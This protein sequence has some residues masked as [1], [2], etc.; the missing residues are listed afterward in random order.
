M[1]NKIKIYLLL[2]ISILF[3]NV[4]IVKADMGAPEIHGYEVTIT[5]TEGATLYDYNDKE[6]Q[7]IPYDTKLEVLYEYESNGEMYASVNYNSKSGV[8]KLS[9]TKP[10]TTEFN[11]E[12][13]DK[14]SSVMKLYVF[15]SGCYLFKGPSKNYDK[16]MEEEIPVGTVLEYEYHDDVWSYVEYDGKSGWIMNYSYSDL[17]SDLYTAVANI[18]SQDSKVMTVSE[19]SELHEEPSADSKVVSTSIPAWEELE[20]KYVYKKAKSQYVYV[21]YEDDAGWMYV[22][23]SEYN[24][25]T[26]N[27]STSV[28]CGYIYIFTD[29]DM[30]SKPNDLNSKVSQKLPSSSEYTYDYCFTKSGKEW[31][32]I[33]YKNK[34]YWIYLDLNSYEEDESFTSSTMVTTY[35]TKDTITLYESPSKDAK[36]VS[37]TI[38]KDVTVESKFSQYIDRTSW[39]YIEYDGIKGWADESSLT[40]QSYSLLCDA[41]ANKEEEEEKS[42][43]TE[44]K[45]D[46]EEESNTNSS[47]PLGLIIAISIGAAI[48]CVLV[49]VVIIVLINKKKK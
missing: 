41:S 9:D 45:E 7:K 34:N 2:I 1:K 47:F 38:S 22:A 24:E 21:E 12:D 33:T 39:A 44:D 31:Y 32:R 13:F 42:S 10:T 27:A 17:Y 6:I 20:Y 30:Y 40:F 5:N 29:K 18:A 43:K 8:V 14:T 3:I 28:N 4:T 15:R 23:A 37:S 25:D 11:L 46:D 26:T 16:V 19:I 36:K 49:A 35:K 48:I